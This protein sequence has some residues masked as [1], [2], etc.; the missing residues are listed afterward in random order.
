[1]RQP[2]YPIPIDVSDPAQLRRTRDLLGQEIRACGCAPTARSIGQSRAAVLSFVG[3]C[4]RPATDLAVVHAIEQRERA[5][6]T[7]RDRVRAYVSEHDAASLAQRA[8][9]KTRDVDAVISGLSPRGP[10]AEYLERALDT[11]DVP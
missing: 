3:S 1:M 11:A 2:R 6:P 5:R 4:A 10:I 8:G 9:V 7:L